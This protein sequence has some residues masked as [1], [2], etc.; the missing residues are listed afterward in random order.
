MAEQFIATFKRPE[1]PASR[2]KY[3]SRVLGIFSEVAQQSGMRR[4]A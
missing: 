3:L 4:V 2:G 1:A